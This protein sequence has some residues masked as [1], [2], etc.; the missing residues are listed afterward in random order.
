[1]D[2]INENTNGPDTHTRQLFVNL[3]F[4]A[5]QERQNEF[6]ILGIVTDAPRGH[7]CQLVSMTHKSTLL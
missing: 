6:K 5:I 2:V 7:I 4:P 3:D 1:M